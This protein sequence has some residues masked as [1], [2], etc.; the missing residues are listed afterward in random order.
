LESKGWIERLERGSYIIIPLEAGPDRV[1]SENPL[2]IGT[3]LEPDGAAAY[4]TAVHHWGWTTQLPRDVFFITSRRR[5]NPRPT[6]L[7]V[8]YRFVTLKP[9]RVFGIAEESADG[10]RVS[11]TDRERT[12]VDIMDRPDLAGGTAEVSEALQQAWGSLDLERLTQY[13]ERLEGGTPPKRLGFLAES[14]SLP[15]VEAWLPRW[16]RL[17]GS[18]FTA[19][20][21]GGAPGGTLLRAWNLRV[22]VSGFERGAHT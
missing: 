7:G 19:L 18:G 20:E 21:R 1:W 22:N 13:L 4:W 5:Y 14:L 17:L 10:F 11:V 12:I 9:Q 2:V 3:L 8:E 15:D 16:R 6:I